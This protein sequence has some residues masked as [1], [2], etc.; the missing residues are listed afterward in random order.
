L[1]LPGWL[2]FFCG[3]EPFLA[4]SVFALLFVFAFQVIA[5]LLALHDYWAESVTQ[6]YL[7]PRIYC[8]TVMIV[9]NVL[10][11]DKQIAVIGALA[12]GSAFARLSASRAFTAIRSCG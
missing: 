12:E 11:T 9:A 2:S 6:K 5:T 7:A 8:N 1:A 10:N 3:G 4:L